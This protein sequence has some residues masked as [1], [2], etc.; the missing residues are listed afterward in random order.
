M[1]KSIE[2]PLVNILKTTQRTWY[3]YHFLA[4]C[5]STQENERKNFE[6][7]QRD[8][9]IIDIYTHKFMLQYCRDDLTDAIKFYRRKFLLWEWERNDEKTKKGR[10]RERE[11]DPKLE[12]K[13]EDEQSES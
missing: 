1:S 13:K 10:E 8:S 12:K 3:Q 9:N 6:K 2:L 11:R 4:L 5:K 7:K